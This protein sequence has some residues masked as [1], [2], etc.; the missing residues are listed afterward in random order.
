MKKIAA[1]VTVLGA[2]LCLT[3]CSSPEADYVSAVREDAPEVLDRG[4]EAD[5]IEFG[6]N[7]CEALSSGD[8]PRE[9]IAYYAGMFT[10]KEATALVENAEAV[11][12]ND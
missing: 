6:Q 3:A 2:L 7:M 12:C 8:T 9:L 10:E 11:L 1:V 4:T 5:L